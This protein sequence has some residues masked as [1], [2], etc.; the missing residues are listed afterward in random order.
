M[1]LVTVPAAQFQCIYN[2]Y[3][4]PGET[5]ETVGISSEAVYDKAER[6]IIYVRY[7]IRLR[8]VV[9]AAAG[10][11]TDAQMDVIR[12]R[13][14][15]PGGAFTYF[16]RG[17]G[18]F[19]IN[20]PGQRKRDSRW[21]PKPRHF[22][23][24][25]WG[26]ANV[27]QLTWEVEVCI[28]EC[29]AARFEDAVM[30][31]NWRV[32]FLIDADG[33]TTRKI[34]GHLRIP[35][36]RDA[37]GNR[38]FRHS[39][40]EYREKIYPQVPEGFRPL[41][42]TFALSE[43]KCTL[44]FSFAD[45]QMG[46]AIPPPGCIRAEGSMTAQNASQANF[47]SNVFTLNAS[48]EL[49]P[50]VAA[51]VAK[52]HFHNMA[53]G[54]RKV[55]QKIVAKEKGKVGPVIP[56][57]WKA[58]EP[59]I[60]GKLKVCSFS[61]TFFAAFNIAELMQTQGLFEPVPDS[62]WQK[63]KASL[64]DLLF[65]T[66]GNAGFKFN[67]KDDLIIDLCASEPE[68]HIL[69]GVRGQGTSRLRTPA[70]INADSSLRTGWVVFEQ[71]FQLM[72]EDS[73]FVHKPYGGSNIVGTRANPTYYV[74]HTGRAIRFGYPIAP[75]AIDRIGSFYLV[76]ANREGDGFNQAIRQGQE[77]TM[78]AAVWQNRYLVANET[79]INGPVVNPMLDEGPTMLTFENGSR[80]VGEGNN[81]ATSS[82]LKGG[83]G[84]LPR[85]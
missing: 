77:E 70:L 29:D 59:K 25:P 71:N 72:P 74:V 57:G 21:G 28:P 35:Q 24:E 75:P 40:D 78:Y 61:V 5:T 9:I 45:E 85:Y 64:G 73:T 16:L 32:E 37:Q 19:R 46:Q 69:K 39:A 8:W 55:I 82:S 20:V 41:P 10:G 42:K 68:T 17:F 6:T 49:A 14:N 44:K 52:G 36:T 76:R 63:W 80:M 12:R 27:A 38:R 3:Q 34:G 84:R 22:E 7:L 30:E 11:T 47:V 26:D 67:P 51:A 65:N 79:G 60:W 62:N 15:S 48:Y 83:V 13:L 1:P 2:G 33:F 81:G 58:A 4:F 18:D 66:R 43:D 50:G 54:R 23:Y 56:W 53:N 31:F